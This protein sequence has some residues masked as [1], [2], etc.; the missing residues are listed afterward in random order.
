MVKGEN[1]M[2]KPTL[3]DFIEILSNHKYWCP[4]KKEQWRRMAEAI[5]RRIEEK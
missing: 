3:E 1:I 2:K 4:S 5:L